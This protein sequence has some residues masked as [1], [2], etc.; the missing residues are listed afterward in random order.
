MTKHVIILGASGQ[1][2][3]EVCLYL[4]QYP[5][6]AV[7]AVA[8]S[9]VSAA[10]LK[11]LGLTVRI[12]QLDGSDA[13]RSLLEGADLV[14]DFSVFS[15][16]N[17]ASLIN[18]YGKQNDR[19][20]AAT[21]AGC[22]FVFI[23][24]INAFGMSEQNNRAQYYCLPRS[25]YAL[26]KRWGERYALRQ[27][28]ARSRQ[29]FV[30][31]LGHVH[32]FLQ[33]VS[34]ET[35]RL[36]DGTFQRFC[37]PDTPS[38]TVFCFS[39]AEAIALAASGKLPMQR[40]TLISA[41]AWSWEEVLQFY[42]REPQSVQV[43]LEAPNSQ[44]WH[45]LCLG[46]AKSALVK[47]VTKNRDL[48]VVWLNKFPKLYRRAQAKHYL[49]SAKLQLASADERATYRA[50]GIHIGSIPGPWVPGL[51]DSRISM[52]A[53]RIAVANRIREKL[54]HVLGDA[55]APNDPY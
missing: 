36:L 14:V 55:E 33:S 31:R 42:Q 15:S 18:F 34:A 17:R 43:V 24:S 45:Q 4:E 9:A 3:T 51:S 52:A 28:R 11:R 37:Y 7:T 50:Q 44:P 6:L 30:F 47:L 25:L 13:D 26:T 46:A 8:R 38:Y 10:V 27:A 16:E 21:K 1:V 49:N 39:I 40:Y 29:A 2:G 48:A 23:S 41:P 19:I 35:Q 32:G 12:G 20:F 22:G 54:G 5:D 53:A